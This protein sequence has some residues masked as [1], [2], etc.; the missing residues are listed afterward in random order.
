MG[1]QVYLNLRYLT[2]NKIFHLVITQTNIYKKKISD[3][4]QGK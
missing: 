1:I 3:F 4:I 2:N